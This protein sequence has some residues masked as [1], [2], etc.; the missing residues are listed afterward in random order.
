MQ[1]ASY[2]TIKTLAKLLQRASAV[3]L[4]CCLDAW[5]AEYGSQLSSL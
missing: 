3:L 2:M 1:K 5:L 4:F